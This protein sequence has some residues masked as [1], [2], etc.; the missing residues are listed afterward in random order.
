MHSHAIASG[1]GPCNTS[2]RSTTLPIRRPLSRAPSQSGSVTAIG[3]D[4]W[5]SNRFV[6]KTQAEPAGSRVR[7]ARSASVCCLALQ[8]TKDPLPFIDYPRSTP[9]STPF[10]L[11]AGYNR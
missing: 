11:L 7:I 1:H 3:R 2:V 4:R 9:M 6:G 5:S 10:L 8:W